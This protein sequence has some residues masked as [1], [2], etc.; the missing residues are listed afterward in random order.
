VKDLGTEEKERVRTF[1]DKH[2]TNEK[3]VGVLI[4]KTSSRIWYRVRLEDV[5]NF[6]TR[7]P[8]KKKRHNGIKQ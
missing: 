4:E 3:P 7:K 8:T 1:L 5:L 6:P 2:S